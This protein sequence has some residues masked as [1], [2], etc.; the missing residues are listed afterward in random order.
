MKPQDLVVLAKLVVIGEKEFTQVSLAQSLYLSQSE[1][2]MSLAR[3]TYASLLISNGREVNQKLFFDFIQFGLS[4]V[5][6]QHPGNIIRGTLTAHSAAPLSSDILSD[7][8]YV[9]P[10][11]KGPARGQSISPLYPTVP[12]AV[13]LDDDFTKY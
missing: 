5:S 8:K 4:V 10:Y 13:L 1:I 9:W 11:S 12:Q 2:S 3:S 7:Q 6:P